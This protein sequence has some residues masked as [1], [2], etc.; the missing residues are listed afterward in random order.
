MD[1]TSTVGEA[2]GFG[3]VCFEGLITVR[4][5]VLM[6]SVEVVAMVETSDDEDNGGLQDEVGGQ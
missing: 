4:V 6:F 1:G 2:D 3:D 5:T